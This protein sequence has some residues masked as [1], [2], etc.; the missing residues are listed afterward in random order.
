MKSLTVISL[1]YAVATIT[2][3]H[4]LAVPTPVV[5]LTWEDG[6]LEPRQAS[7]TTRVADAA[8]TNGPNTRACWKAGFSI[9][10]DFDKKLPPEGKTVT[11]DLE[12]TNTTMA[13]D[14]YK[15]LIMAINGQHR[16]K[17]HAMT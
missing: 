7:S 6:A 16:E 11:Y 5:E 4:A 3:A 17:H 12:I 1:A 9:A 15:R 2:P 10:T 8:C 13:P 14:G